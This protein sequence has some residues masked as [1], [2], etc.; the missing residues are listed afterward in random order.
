MYDVTASSSFKSLESWRD[1]FLIQASPREPDRFPF[2]VIGNKIDLDSRE[3]SVVTI[4]HKSVLHACT[5][6]CSEAYFTD[7]NRS[8]FKQHSYE[9][10][11]LS[12]QRSTGVSQNA[13]I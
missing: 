8:T 7:I 10:D 4:C 1:E 9:D 5:C 2:V 13:Y 11:L 6:G 3:V 12:D